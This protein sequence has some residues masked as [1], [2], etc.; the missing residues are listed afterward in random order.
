MPELITPLEILAQMNILL[1][2]TDQETYLKVIDICPGNHDYIITPTRTPLDDDLLFF[3][4]RPHQG[5]YRL[6][7]LLTGTPDEGLSFSVQGKDEQCYGFTVDFTPRK[8]NYLQTDPKA[9][10]HIVPLSEYFARV[11]ELYPQDRL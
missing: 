7:D 3:H 6:K 10:H 2:G 5:C 8:Q 4:L 9:V 1:G 11:S